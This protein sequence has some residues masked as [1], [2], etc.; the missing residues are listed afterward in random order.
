MRSASLI[1]TT[2]GRNNYSSVIIWV[3]NL[4]SLEA[5]CYFLSLPTPDG[6]LKSLQPFRVVWLLTDAL[7][8]VRGTRAPESQRRPRVTV[9][10]P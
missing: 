8:E 9:T 6:I 4:D 10:A 5:G 7:A 2:C 1:G 3:L